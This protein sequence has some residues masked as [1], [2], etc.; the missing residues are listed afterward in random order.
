MKV[1][2]KSGIKGWQLKL[3]TVYNS[4]KELQAYDSNYNIAS[5]L[6]YST[7]N[8]AWEDNPTIQ[9]SINPSDLCKIS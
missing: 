6:G 4:L 7:A 9:G 2:C 1:I 5:R 3:R 8:K